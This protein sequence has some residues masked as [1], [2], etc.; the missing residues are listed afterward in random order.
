MPNAACS[1]VLSPWASAA[2]S[3]CGDLMTPLGEGA[4]DF[5]DMPHILFEVGSI[6]TLE[7]ALVLLT[8]MG[9]CVAVEMLMM[10]RALPGFFALSRGLLMVWSLRANVTFFG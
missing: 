8:P 7:D 9:E 1:L 3:G 4:S 5:C 2:F 6:H 10:L